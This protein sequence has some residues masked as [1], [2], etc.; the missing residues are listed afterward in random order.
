MKW[1]TAE[2]LN[3]D[4]AAIAGFLIES[5]LPGFKEVAQADVAVFPSGGNIIP[6]V[7]FVDAHFSPVR[8]NG[9]QM[10]KGG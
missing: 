6:A 7:D 8:V 5:D 1:W 4:H 10:S 9:G 3:A 2:L